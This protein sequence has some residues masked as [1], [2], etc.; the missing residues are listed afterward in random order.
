MVRIKA[1]ML[2]PLLLLPLPAQAG[3]CGT[4]LDPMSVAATGMGFGNYLAASA[5]ASNSTIT[6]S[7]G[8]LG[9]DLLPSFTVALSAGSSASMIT[10]KMVF[11]A[12]KLNYNIY[13]NSGYATVWGDGTGG[14]VTQ[15]I[16]GSV[17][18]LSS[19]NFTAFGL[20][21]AGQFVT[22]G[23]PYLDTITVSVTF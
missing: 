14:S 5:S 16:T 11:G 4:F 12:Q 22:A 23:G 18:Q 19:T 8:L 2:A 1:V 10:R 7:C 6:I 20:L 17:L 21:P 15:S 3:L 9:I 13:T